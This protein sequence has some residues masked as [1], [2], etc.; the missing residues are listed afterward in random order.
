M[1][2]TKRERRLS[3]TLEEESFLKL[4]TPSKNSYEGFKHLIAQHNLFASMA[5]RR[6]QLASEQEKKIKELESQVN[7]RFTREREAA[8]FWRKMTVFSCCVTFV[9]LAALFGQLY[10]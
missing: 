7:R 10:L 2:T 3:I 8:V 5:E 9:A 1:I 4:Q 6:A